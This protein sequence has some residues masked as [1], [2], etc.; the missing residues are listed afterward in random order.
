MAEYTIE[1]LEGLL[2]RKC[3]AISDAEQIAILEAISVLREQAARVLDREEALVLFDGFIKGMKDTLD[4]FEMQNSVSD[5]LK[6]ST[7][8]RIRLFEAAISVLREQGWVRTDDKTSE[9]FKDNVVS[10]RFGVF[11][12][13]EREILR[14]ALA[15]SDVYWCIGSADMDPTDYSTFKSLCI[16]MDAAMRARK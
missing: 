16:E 2:A 9:Q 10:V 5:A 8:E 1:V 4:K 14:I 11:S 7:R 6:E 15:Y 3:Y 12:A 13:K